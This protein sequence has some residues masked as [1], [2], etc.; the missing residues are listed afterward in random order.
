MLKLKN[1]K[2]EVEKKMKLIEE[3]EL[4]DLNQTILDVFVPYSRLTKS[5]K[6]K[7]E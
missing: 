1:E 4:N 3:E 2:N 7:L 6:L 5:L